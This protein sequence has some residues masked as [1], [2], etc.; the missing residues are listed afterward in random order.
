MEN[1][2]KDERCPFHGQL[3][4][5]GR[6]FKGK[7]IKKFPTRVVIALDK[8]IFLKKYERFAKRIT[9]MH[10]HLPYCLESKINVGD[11]IKIGECRKLSKIIS[12][13][14]LEKLNSTGENK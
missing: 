10:A 12:Q 1:N 14:V 13:V 4:T 7:V 3:K 11:S 5:R 2:C 6:E 8:T 9:K